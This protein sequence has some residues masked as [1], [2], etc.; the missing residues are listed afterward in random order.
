MRLVLG[1]GT[2]LVGIGV[3]IGTPGI[4]LAGRLVRGVL[5]GV[6][7]LDPFTLLVVAIGLG[8]VAM[9]ACYVPARRV[10]AIDP[11]HSL[12]EG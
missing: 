3:L 1:E 10:L 6:S 8:L 9:V 11:A 7:P 2:V 12:R 5:V 4:Y